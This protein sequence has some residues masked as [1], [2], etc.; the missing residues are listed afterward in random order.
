MS[1]LPGFYC[2]FHWQDLLSLTEPRAH[3][4]KSSKRRRVIGW[5]LFPPQACRHFA[6][7]IRNPL[8][9]AVLVPVVSLGTGE[10]RTGESGLRH[11]RPGWISAPSEV[12]KLERSGWLAERDLV[13]S[14]P[15]CRP[16]AAG[17]ERGLARPSLG[18]PLSPGPGGREE[19]AWRLGR[20][21]TRTPSAG[22]QRACLSAA[23]AHL[24]TRSGSCPGDVHAVFPDGQL[25]LVV[26]EVSVPKRRQG[27]QR[28]PEG[29]WQ[30]SGLW[31]P[32]A[33]E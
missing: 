22:T 8:K 29:L 11:S 14:P 27:R 31:P 32:L 6:E 16:G 21:D 2:P 19:A 9:A 23:H 28:F 30:R 18:P 4:Y 5:L 17:I 7:S 33:D 10:S 12:G 26:G 20:K 3:W 24:A 15:S 1:S 13:P 25:V